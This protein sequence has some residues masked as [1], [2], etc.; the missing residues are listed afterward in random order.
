MIFQ[1]DELA[2]PLIAFLG[3]GEFDEQSGGQFVGP[4][5]QFIISVELVGDSLFRGDLLGAQHFLHLV[6]DRLG[7]FE[8]EGEML[9]DRQAAQAFFGD[10]QGAQ[11]CAQF[12]VLLKR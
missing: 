11:E 5:Q 1:P 6:P 10:K 12:I 7:V 2:Q 3:V 4:G 9:A 8:Q